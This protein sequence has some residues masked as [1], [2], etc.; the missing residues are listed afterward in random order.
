MTRVLH[1][2]TGPSGAGKS[3]FCRQQPDWEHRIHN[4]DDMARAHGEVEDPNVREQAWRNMVKRMTEKMRAGEAPI[5]LD[6]VLD[7]R[8]IDEAVSPALEN[9]Y[10][11][12]LTVICPGHPQIC[13][14]RVRVRKAEGGHGRTPETVRQIY[15]NA[16]HVASEASVLCRKTHLIDSSGHGFRAVATIEDFEL[17]WSGESRPEWVTSYF[18]ADQGRQANPKKLTRTP[19]L[20]G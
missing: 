3:A 13:A 12:E 15:G 8:A 1:V 10:D 2:V 11:I 16:L 19:G 17:R 20:T 5:V 14:E 6:H 9:G 7:T 18:L 4:L